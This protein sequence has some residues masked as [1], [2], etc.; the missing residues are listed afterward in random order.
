MEERPAIARLKQGDIG[1]LET[2][3]RIYQVRAVRAAYLVVRDRAL[4]ED[5]VQAAFVRAYE[6]IGQFDANRPFGPWFLKSVINDSLK[7][8]TQQ[9]RNVS[10]DWEAEREDTTWADRLI[11]P[12]PG[13]LEMAESADMQ[14]MVQEALG[15]LTPAQRT[16]V[17]LRYF[18]D[19]S[20]AEMT[21][22]LNRPPGTV[23]WL[24]YAARERLRDILSSLL[25]DSGSHGSQVSK[26]D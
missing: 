17:V 25:P 6:R 7:A 15:Q 16:A 26:N 11:D 5:I 3:V 22:K 9:Q 12:A 2:L 10:L 13:P 18:L 14:R 19:F 24:L 23:R 21:T 1:G 4:A 20:E 8:I